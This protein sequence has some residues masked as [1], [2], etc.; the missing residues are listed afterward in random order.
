MVDPTGRYIHVADSSPDQIE[1]WSIN[2]AD[3]TLGSVGSIAYTGVNFITIDPAARFGYA[4]SN[5]AIPGWVYYQLPIGT[6]GSLQSGSTLQGPWNPTTAAFTP[7]GKF[8]YVTDDT[9]ST[10]SLT[11]NYVW[12]FPVDPLTG[13]VGA[14]SNSI[15]VGV[16]PSAVAVDPSG[17]FAYVT[18]NGSGGNNIYAYSINASTGAL[19]QIGSPLRAGG[20]PNWVT[21]TGTWE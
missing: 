16:S 15:T 3:G 9:P 8:L 12:I 13:N 14:A 10:I 2:T 17:R 5:S 20:G 11:L 1:T 6:D 4:L 7:S 19:T 21:V 18:D